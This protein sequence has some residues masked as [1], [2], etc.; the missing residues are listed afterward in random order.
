[1]VESNL[2]LKL[3]SIL[4]IQ[5]VTYNLKHNGDLELGNFKNI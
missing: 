1:M 5:I 2:K 3:N 4:E